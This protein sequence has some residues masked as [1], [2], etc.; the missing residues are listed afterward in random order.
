MKV[1]E[2]RSALEALGPEYDDSMVIV[3]VPGMSPPEEATRLIT[4]PR[5]TNVGGRMSFETFERV[6]WIDVGGSRVS[7]DA[8]QEGWSVPYFNPILTTPKTP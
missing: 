2:L 5:M 7:Q 4:I 6:V 1:S 3:C 8:E